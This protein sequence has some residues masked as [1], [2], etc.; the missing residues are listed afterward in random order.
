MKYFAFLL[1][2]MTFVA[3]MAQD[4]PSKEQR[5]KNWLDTQ[6]ADKDGQITLDESSGRMQANFRRIDANGDGFI[7]QEELGGLAD[8]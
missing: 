5:I 6:D 8:R 2:G 4:A 1:V 7:D 3:A